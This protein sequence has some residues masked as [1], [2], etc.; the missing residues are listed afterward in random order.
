MY[1]ASITTVPTKPGLHGTAVE[2][3]NEDHAASWCARV[4]AEQGVRVYYVE[5][6]CPVQAQHDM[7]AGTY[8]RARALDER[9]E[10][11]G[12]IDWSLFDA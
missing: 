4:G 1:R 10:S 12:G 6:E 11:G 8:G 9:D 7:D 5:D 2:F 3:I